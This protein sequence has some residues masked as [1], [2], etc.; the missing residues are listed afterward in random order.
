M[1]NDDIDGN[2]LDGL[3][4]KVLSAIAIH[5]KT[6]ASWVKDKRL[7]QGRKS[8]SEVLKWICLH[9]DRDNMQIAAN[10]IGVSVEDL[11]AAG[12][13]FQRT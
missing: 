11:Q 2:E 9:L 7:E 5:G 12:R 1:N 13:V 6:P 10:A 3:S 4:E 8:R